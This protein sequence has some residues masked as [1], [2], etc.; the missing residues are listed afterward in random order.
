MTLPPI[1]K[2]TTE[3]IILLSE[4]KDSVPTEYFLF[5]IL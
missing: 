4:N 1:V 5:L 2:N 3:S